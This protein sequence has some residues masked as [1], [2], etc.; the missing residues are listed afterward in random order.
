[1]KI[2]KAVAAI[3]RNGDKMFVLA[4][5]YSDYKGQ[6]EFLGGK[7]ES[8]ETLQQSLISEIKEELNTDIEVRSLI[9]T[10]GFGLPD[11]L[12]VHELFLV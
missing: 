2:F 5:G 11:I 3:I 12:P 9:G 4:R 10:I 7:I 1:M 6:Q 8:D